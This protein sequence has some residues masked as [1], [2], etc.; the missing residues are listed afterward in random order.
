MGLYSEMLEKEKIIKNLEDSK[1][2]IIIVC[3]GCACDSIAYSLDYPDRRVEPSGDMAQDAVAIN[4][5]KKEWEEELEKQGKTV[6]YFWISDPC[7]LTDFECEDLR[8]ETENYDTVAVLGCP[9]ACAGIHRAIKDSKKKIVPMMKVVGS[10]VFH[11]KPD[12][13]NENFYIDKEASYVK[14]F[15]K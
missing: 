9:S 4:M 1:K 15:N 11:M 2:V 6:G 8:R 12:E 7:K 14:L 5:V 13:K 3:P 10:Y